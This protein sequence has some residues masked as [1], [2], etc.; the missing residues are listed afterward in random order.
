MAKNRRV[1]FIINSVWGL[2]DTSL[3]SNNPHTEDD[4]KAKIKNEVLL[5]SLA[6]LQHAIN[7]MFWLCVMHKGNHF[8]HLL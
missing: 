3:F 2:T 8:Q 7:N 6:E 1:Y 4:L 5:V